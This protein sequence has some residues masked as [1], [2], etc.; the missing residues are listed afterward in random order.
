M[1]PRGRRRAAGRERRALAL[2][3][4]ALVCWTGGL[5]ALTFRLSGASHVLLWWVLPS[6][7]AVAVAYF[8]PRWQLAALA[9]SGVLGALVTLEISGRLLKFVTL[10]R[11]PLHKP[12][13]RSSAAMVGVTAALAVPPLLAAL[14]RTNPGVL[15]PLG[16]LR[17]AAPRSPSPSPIPTSGRSGCSWSTWRERAAW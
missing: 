9:V 4:A 3:A 17:S 11:F 5:L 14:H 10:G 6:A 1:G 15:K 13:I 8:R 7:V 2:S 12:F 16:A